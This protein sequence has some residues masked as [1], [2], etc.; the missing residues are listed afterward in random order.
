MGKKITLGEASESHVD[1]I[2]INCAN[3]TAH[4]GGCTHGVEMTLLHAIVLWGEDA[5]LD[6]LP[7]WC[8]RCGSRRIDVRPIFRAASGNTSALIRKAWS[9][10]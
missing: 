6:N 5:R 1:G 10:T 3:W 4:G 2:Q 8:S 7:L 9:R